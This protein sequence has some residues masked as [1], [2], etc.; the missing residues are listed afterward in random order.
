VTHD[1]RWRLALP[2][3]SETLAYSREV[4]ERVARRLRAGEP[5]QRLRYFTWLC[6]FH[7]DMHAEAF[8]TMRQ[9]LA[10]PPPEEV[11]RALAAAPP[12][13]R[14]EP[15]RAPT[16]VEVA[17]ATF[18]LGARPDDPFVFDNEKWAHSVT[19]APF[20]VARCAVT[21]GEFRAFVQ[22]DGY[23]RRELWSDAGWRWREGE[24]VQLPGTWRRTPDG[25]F[26]RRRFDRWLPLEDDLPVAHVSWYEAEAFCAFAGRRLPTEAEWQ[27]A[28]GGAA[29]ERRR[30]WGDAPPGPERANLD[31]RRGD[32]AP[33][34]ALPAGDS[35]C[36]ARQMLG[37]VWE[38]TASSF[39][40][41]PGFSPDAYADYS[42]PWFGTR[43]V[44][45][46]GSWMTRARLVHGG[47]R[48]FFEP[49]RRDVVAGFRTCAR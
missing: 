8:T 19:V 17:G 33:V 12:D 28:A 4:R 47:W 20:R 25:G 13:E 34:G 49:W 23:A 21:Q 35:P 1:S 10:L 26:E 43:K 39:E 46:G 5:D 6:V 2:S 22:A 32:V 48:N 16:D 45:R 42:A 24:A 3:R 18:E 7:E 15:P 14:S 11:A 36:G 9:T 30:P 37:N 40:P 27:L 44:L 41:Y 38:W 31:A 29:H